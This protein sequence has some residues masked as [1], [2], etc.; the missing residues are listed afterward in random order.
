M[1]KLLVL[2]FALFF[3]N[4]APLAAQQYYIGPAGN[5]AN[6][7]LSIATACVTPGRVVSI[8]PTGVGPVDL[9]LLAG[10][11]TFNVNVPH[12]RYLRVTGDC[13]VPS[14][15]VI[16]SLPSREIFWAQD[17]ATIVA[18][19]FRVQTTTNYSRVFQARQY[20]IIDFDNVEF[21]Y[22]PMGQYVSLHETSRANCTGTNWLVQTSGG[23]SGAKHFSVTEDK[24]TISM[25]CQLIATSPT[26]F[27][28]AMSGTPSP[29]H[30]GTQWSLGNYVGFSYTGTITGQKYFLQNSEIDGASLLPGSGTTADSLSAIH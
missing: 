30:K 21:G 10:S 17:H 8:M 23:N 15:V 19:C 29:F 9:K 3:G 13:N 11:Y 27:I 25:A 20:A 5:D 22:F 12:Y 4:A 1:K 6:D 2:V 16:T 28:D 14:N 7:C 26:A 18:R 24:S